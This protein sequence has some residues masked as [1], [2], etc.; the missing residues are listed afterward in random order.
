MVVEIM[1]QSTMLSNVGRGQCLEGRPI[2]FHLPPFFL[3]D[4]QHQTFLVYQCH[5][6][7]TQYL[8]KTNFS[9]LL[10][11]ITL[12]FFPNPCNNTEIPA[13]RPELAG[14]N[15]VL[16]LHRL[17]PSEFYV[18]CHLMFLFFILHTSL[19]GGGGHTRFFFR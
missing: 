5:L 1:N 8:L 19:S 6:K 11:N 18:S 13:P 4:F 16:C 2:F 9:I 15:Y 3:A 14:L 10:G 17:Q 7:T 12:L